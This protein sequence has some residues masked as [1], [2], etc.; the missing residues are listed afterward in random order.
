MR[1]RPLAACIAAAA[2][3]AI[4]SRA[5]AEFVSLKFDKAVEPTADVY[6]NGTV[7]PNTPLGPFYWTENNLPPNTN[8]PPPTS[9][10]CIELG[11]GLPAVGTTGTFGVTNPANAPTIKDGA[12]PAQA[13]A[14]AAAISEL[15]ARFYNNAWDS[16]SFTGSTSAIAFQLALWE[17][18]Y[19]GPSATATSL[20]DSSS[21]FYVKTSD[22]PTSI[23]NQAQGWLNAL[24]G[25]VSFDS[26]FPGQELVALYAPVEGA[27][28]DQP[29]QDQITKR[30]RAA[31]P[32][33]PGVVLAGMG[34]LAL[35]GG[36]LRWRRSVSA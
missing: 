22:I 33:P 34:F 5:S 11:G 12:T 29:W 27:G 17:L 30:P 8:F 9:T 4:T 36:R 14:K 26:V 16:A 10:F 2:L 1:S 19:D 7:Q 31:V 24:N 21:H 13:D 3:L 35:L 18:V 32:A 25:S 15:Y 28:K 6:L 20:T 23:V